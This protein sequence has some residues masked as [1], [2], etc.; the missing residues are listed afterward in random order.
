[1]PPGL[2][3]DSSS[4]IISGIPTKAGT[5]TFNVAV[6]D[7]ASVTAVQG[8]SITI[9]PAILI[10]PNT[11]PYPQLHQAYK[12]TIHGTGGTGTLSYGVTT[13]SLPPGLSLNS[14]TG[15]LSGALQVAGIYSFTITATDTVGATGSRAYTV[16]QSRL[17][18]S[19]AVPTTVHPGT[20]LTFAIT[21]TNTSSTGMT[22]VQISDALPGG[23]SLVSAIL[24]TKPVQ[25]SSSGGAYSVF[26][27]SLAAHASVTLYVTVSVPTD[28]AFGVVL[29]NSVSATNAAGG[30]QNQAFNSV[31]V[32]TTAPRFQN[33]RQS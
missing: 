19:Q 8:Y 33:G 4:G 16:A 3:L 5:Y 28:T 23:T 14:K 31:G 18:I 25:P 26:V 17:A 22:G 21:I 32:I 9:N 20:Q 12:Q 10:S 13:G 1:M 29:T 15:V 6:T 7:A 27:G 24:G 30:A 2:S 11:L